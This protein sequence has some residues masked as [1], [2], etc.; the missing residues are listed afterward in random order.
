MFVQGIISQVRKYSLL[1]SK[2]CFVPVCLHVLLYAHGF[3][4]C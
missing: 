4:S 1:F 2:I 3:F